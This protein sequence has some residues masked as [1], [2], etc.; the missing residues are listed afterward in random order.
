MTPELIESVLSNLADYIRKGDR[1]R[2]ATEKSR[3]AWKNKALYLEDE[4]KRLVMKIPAPLNNAQ[5]L[6]SRLKDRQ[7]ELELIIDGHEYK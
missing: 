5:R 4:V 1:K 2:I 7:K 6:L 3:D